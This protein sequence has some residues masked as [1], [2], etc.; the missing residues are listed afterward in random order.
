[1]SPDDR[2]SAR[3]RWLQ[4][5]GVVLL[6]LAGVTRVVLTLRDAEL[7]NGEPGF[8]LD[9]PWIHLQFAKNLHAYGSFSY[10]ANEQV[11]AGSTSPLYTF[12]L[13]AGFFI[14]SDEMMLSYVL[15]TLFFALSGFMFY[16][17]L[18]LSVPGKWWIPLLG[19]LLFVLEPRMQWAAQSG[20]ETTLFIAGIISIFFAFAARRWRLLGALLGLL[21]WVRPEASMLMVIMGVGA[22]IEL[23]STSGTRHDGHARSIS[24]KDIWV[25]ARIPLAIVGVF[26]VMYALFNLSLSGTVLPNTFAAKLRYYGG[27]GVNFPGQVFEFLTAKHMIVISLFSV[28]GIIVSVVDA[29]KVRRMSGLMHVLW[30]LV[31]FGAYW[32][33]LPF[34]FQQGRYLMPIIPSYL[35]LGVMGASW[36]AGIASRKLFRLSP[37]PADAIICVILL[38]IAIL[39]FGT[40]NAPNAEEYAET[41]KYILDRQVRTARWISSHLPEDAV[42]ATHDIGAI[43]YYS[44]RHIVDMVGLVTP[45]AIKTID[46]LDS[47]KSFLA[48]KHVTHLAVL[49]DWFEI[50]NVGPLFRTDE[51]YPEIMEVFPFDQSRIH[52][53]PKQVS[54]MYNSAIQNL[55]QGR[56]SIAGPLLEKAVAMDPLYARGHYAL[57]IALRAA[58]RVAE[59]ETSLTRAVQLSPDLW[60][61]QVALAEL[62]AAG[63]KTLEAIHRL[64]QNLQPRKECALAYKLLRDLCEREEGDSEAARRYGEMYRTLEQATE[65]Q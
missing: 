50:G 61:A 62:E 54:W 37:R 60:R 12:L 56:L 24:M 15:G 17:L 25:T 46:N 51:N 20:M 40:A 58:G 44:S 39:K 27:K 28:V 21:L 4:T 36:I 29:V 35:F 64:E 10:F 45:A 33:K 1:M 48:R 23:L 13:A 9:D 31:M 47:L 55:A 2:R 63:G 49:R 18:R 43:G 59:A 3:L 19:T 41:C 30:I 26:S 38:G 11:T 14:T 6:I 57:G 65:H 32:S 7:A 16:F 52:F 22:T 34:L 5:L 53:V 42:V 8:P